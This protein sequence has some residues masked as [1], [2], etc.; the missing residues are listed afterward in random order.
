MLGSWVDGDVQTQMQRDTE[1]KKV[2]C[3]DRRKRNALEIRQN[4]G[5]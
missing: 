4:V 1:D 3:V 2:L 5:V